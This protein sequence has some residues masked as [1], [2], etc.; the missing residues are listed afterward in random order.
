MK[1]TTWMTKPYIDRVLIHIGTETSGR[2][3]KGSGEDPEQHNP[4][5]LGTVKKLKAQ[6]LTDTEIGV[7][8]NMSTKKMR[9]R[10]SVE[11]SAER[12]ELQGQASRLRERGMS[13]AAIRDHMGLPNESSVRSLLNKRSQAKAKADEEG[14]RFLRESIAKSKYVDV[15]HGV[16]MHVGI[17][18]PKLD[19]AISI[20]TYEGYKTYYIDIDQR[21]AGNKTKMK[22]LAAPGI[23]WTEVNNNRDNI[24]IPGFHSEDGGATYKKIEPV[25]H[26]SSDRV[27]IAYE[28]PKDGTIELR[29]GVEDLNLNG[30][31]YAQ[32]RIGVNGTHYMK[33]MAIYGDT[34]PAGKDIIYHT[35][36]TPENAAKVFKPLEINKKTGQI[37][38][39]NPFGSSVMQRHYTDKD[40]KDQLS[41][42]NIVGS[43]KPNE[44]GRWSEWSKSL[45]SQFLSKQTPTLAKT[46]LGKAFQDKLDEYEEISAVT[47]PTVKKKLLETFSDTCDSSAIHLKGAAMP[48]QTSSVL[49]AIESIKENEIYSPKHIP[50]EMVIL[51]RH[52]HGGIFE[53]PSLKVIDKN[54]EAEAIMKN[55]RDGVGI[56]PKVA[57]QLSG[58]DF[59]GDTVLVIP[60]PDKAIKYKG[61]LD[62]LKG[63]DPKASYPPYPGIPDMKDKTL[64]TEM[65]KIS[66]LITDM[67]IKGATDDKLTRAVRHSMVVIDSKKHHLDYKRSAKEHNIADLKREFQGGPL[68]GASTIISKSG[69]DVRVPQMND[70]LTVVNPKTG[71]NKRFYI[72]PETGKKL[73]SPITTLAKRS[74][75]LVLTR[76][77]YVRK[78]DGKIMT[79]LIK[80]KAMETVEDAY[81][82]TSKPTPTIM[83][84]VYAEHA[85]K[86]KALA[87]KSRLDYLNTKDIPYSKTA[88]K[89]YAPEVASL[90]AALR[91][92]QRHAPLER[93]AQ[94]LAGSRVKLRLADNPDMDP[95]EIK[96][97]RGEEIAAMRRLMG[98]G[99][100]S[101]KIKDKEWEAIQAG[102]VTKSFLEE[103]LGQTDI[104]LIKERALPRVNEIDTLK[105]SKRNRA[106]AMYNNGV[107]RG[108]I[109]KAL[110]I[111][112]GTLDKII[113]EDNASG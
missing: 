12:R 14:A 106:V 44:E 31:R 90:K 103:I 28:S 42:L 50:G 34:I 11:L 24:G 79:R 35:N 16:E 26:I 111:S 22:V 41:P 49:I 27:H 112:I 51:V 107:S 21:G 110:G 97:M 81:T 101:I 32:V 33:G 56:N 64:Q 6:G 1:E 87:N 65:G 19:A 39:E 68:K 75:G 37:D 71:K 15:G 47:N 100:D 98:P 36:K 86:L 7:A 84:I 29:R 13:L 9:A 59:D 94:I 18:R 78:S 74:D 54:P 83:E 38:Q 4:T 52:P 2:Y 23:S 92:A 88:A 99:K 102:A 58:A 61:T 82:L 60:N 93:K 76:A 25:K 45:S 63:F 85:N 48:R 73:S 66:N 77:Q 91:L 95:D 3:P 10:R 57:Q 20:L 5:F 89:T 67:T 55:S 69:S 109:A 104:D 113:E 96:K 17:S 43:T 105:G 8:M 30:K 46:Q 108:S 53:I 62:G 80:K 40:G 70:F 72:D